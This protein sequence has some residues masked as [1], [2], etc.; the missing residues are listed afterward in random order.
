V[1]QHARKRSAR[2]VGA[3][4]VIAVSAAFALPTAAVAAAEK[5]PGVGKPPSGTGMGTAAALDNPVCNKDAEPAGYGQYE[6]VQESGYLGTVCVAVWKG[7]ENGGATAQGA[8][9]DRVKVAVILPN[10]QQIGQ[11]VSRSQL[12][13]NHATGQPGTVENAIKDTLA[14]F[15]HSFETYGR[16]V[17]LSFVTS[18]GSDEAAQRADA[19]TVAATKPFAALDAT[20]NGL[21]VF[22]TEIAKAK[23]PVWSFDTSLEAT[24]EQAPYRWGQTDTTAGAINAA[25]FVGK[26]LVGKKAEHA[27]S[28]DLQGQTRKIGMVFGSNVTDKDTLN[29]ALASNGVKIPANAIIDYPAST[30][31]FGDPVKAAELAPTAVAKL[32]DAGVTSVLL[33]ADSGMVGA[34]TKAATANDFH[35]EWIMGGYA[36]MDLPIFARGY[37]QE[38][39][40]H[41]FGLSSF[42]VAASDAVREA[43]ATTVTNDPVQWYYGM[44]KGTSTSFM[45]LPVL[46]LMQGIMYAGPKLTAQTF[47][48]GHFAAPATGG[49]AST[50]G[51]GAEQGYGRTNGLPYDEYQRGNKDFSLVWWDPDTIGPQVGSVPGGK[52]TSWYIDD[53]KRYAA[54]KW[55]KKP[56]KFFDKSNAI[57]QLEEI[58]TGFEAPVQAPCPGCPSETGQGAPAA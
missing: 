51:L 13:V 56:I 58:P 30:S 33:L 6:F 47:K 12:P 48:Q 10:E 49:A 39:W 1:G 5:P 26:Q 16:T 4:L 57:Y 46:W 34:M 40:R 22:A 17:E 32:K 42:P 37:D 24:L 29:K 36:Y 50:T 7:K 14:A 23:I 3:A 27:G 20:F 43:M 38:Q 8:T 31:P 15:Q 41:A 54:G 25:E 19:V 9:K 55:P 2:L 52:G 35:P 28:P 18:T 44:G 11:V 53:G 45:T 21:N